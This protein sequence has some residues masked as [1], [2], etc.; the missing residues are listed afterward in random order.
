[1]LYIQKEVIN[2]GT[3]IATNMTHHHLYAP[4]TISIMTTDLA[5]H[6]YRCIKHYTKCNYMYIQRNSEFAFDV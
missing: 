2:V 5:A 1:M 4:C 6:T 3:K